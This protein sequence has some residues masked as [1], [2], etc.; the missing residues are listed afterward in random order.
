MNP[1]IV[2]VGAVVAC[3]VYGSFFEWFWHKYWMHYP[4]EPKE[5]FRGHTIVHHGLYKGDDSFFVEEELHAE[6]VLLKPYALPGLIA[7]HLPIIY[8]IDRYWLPHTAL[9]FFLATLAYFVVYEFTHYNMHVPRKQF[10]ERFAW[11]RFLRQHH[12]LHHRYMQKNF[13]VLIPLADWMCGT[14]ITEKTL[15]KQKAA[16][17]AA[18]ASGQ[19]LSKKPV[20]S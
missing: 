7:L 2:Q 12:K 19:P 17:E 4:R 11:F 15:A 6:H 1:I 14:M 10:V 5:A 16:R 20:R 3:G 13:C 18:I 8:L 9:T